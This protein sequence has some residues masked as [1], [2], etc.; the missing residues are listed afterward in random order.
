MPHTVTKTRLVQLLNQAETQEAKFWDKELVVSFKLKSGFTVL[1]RAACVDPA[2]FVY[3]TGFKI[4]FEDALRKLWDLEGY[5]LQ[6]RLAG[7]IEDK[8]LNCQDVQN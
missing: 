7:H 6:L 1:G 3:E 8:R 5:V 4:A 2:N